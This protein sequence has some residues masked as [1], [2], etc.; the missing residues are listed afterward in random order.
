MYIFIFLDKILQL[1]TFFPLHKNFITLIA[2]IVN[3]FFKLYELNK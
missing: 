2:V 3:V 1:K